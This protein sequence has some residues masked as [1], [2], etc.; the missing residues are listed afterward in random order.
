M[1]NSA[2]KGSRGSAPRFP[3]LTVDAL[4]WSHIWGPTPCIK[5][6]PRQ[7]WPVRIPNAC[8]PFAPAIM[9][10]DDEAYI[11][12]L[13]DR[14]RR[15]NAGS[16]GAPWDS[17]PALRAGL[18]RPWS[19]IWRVQLLRRLV[20]CVDTVRLHLGLR[21][22]LRVLSSHDA[23]RTVGDL[24]KFLWHAVAGIFG[25]NSTESEGEQTGI[26]REQIRGTRVLHAPSP[27][28]IG[29][30][31][32]GSYAQLIGC[33]SFRISVRVVELFAENLV[34]RGAPQSPEQTPGLR[35]GGALGRVQDS[36][37]IAH[38]SL[39]FSRTQSVSSGA[40]RLKPW[41]SSRP[42]SQ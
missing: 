26:I 13:I 39:D 38:V 18:Y 15:R 14:P 25:V 24:E 5:D 41:H 40:R 28:E 1:D 8:P 9:I 21:L 23:N 42:Q 4:A 35:S 29:P 32:R 37:K 36:N 34:G 6:Q 27:A 22:R 7:G 17:R 16:E 12:V 3:G 2:A 10:L 31:R 30:C 11:V 33:V 19:R 20:L